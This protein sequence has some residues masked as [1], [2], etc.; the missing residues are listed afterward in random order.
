MMFMWYDSDVVR[1][2]RRRS[3]LYYALAVIEN[4]T[5]MVVTEI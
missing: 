1:C 4:M 2:D 3:R 5:T